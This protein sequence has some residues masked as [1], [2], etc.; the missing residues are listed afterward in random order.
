MRDARVR[1]V[2]ERAG[3]F[4]LSS[5]GVF[6]DVVVGRSSDLVRNAGWAG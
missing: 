5:R 1:A 4:R 6:E 2:R 3:L